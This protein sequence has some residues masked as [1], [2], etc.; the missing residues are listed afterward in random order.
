MISERGESA[1]SPNRRRAP[2][3]AAPTTCPP[4]AAAPPSVTPTG[5]GMGRGYLCLR[6]EWGTGTGKVIGGSFHGGGR[7]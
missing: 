6:G 2:A 5:L 1:S 7:G 3:D 4:G